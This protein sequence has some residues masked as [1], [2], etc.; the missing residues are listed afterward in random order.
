MATDKSLNSLLNE[1]GKEIDQE[2]L[3]ASGEENQKMHQIAK[4][5]LHLERDLTLPGTSVQES[6]RIERLMQFIEG[7]D[8]L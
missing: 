1:L 7:E 6:A 4:R 2:T 3:E 8:I 5:I